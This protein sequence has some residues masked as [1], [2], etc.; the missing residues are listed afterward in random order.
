MSVLRPYAADV[1]LL[2]E[3]Q[4]D[5]FDHDG[6]RK[7]VAFEDRLFENCVQLRVA[8]FERSRQAVSRRIEEL[9]AGRIR[10][11][12]GGCRA[13]GERGSEKVTA[14]C[15]HDAMSSCAP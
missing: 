12:C 3:Q 10:K 7:Q 4:L 6:V 8:L 2:I 14:A 1:L 5:A 11:S 15:L 9:C 13:A